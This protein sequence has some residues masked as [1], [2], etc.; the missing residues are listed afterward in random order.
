MRGRW[1]SG[2]VFHV[3]LHEVLLLYTTVFVGEGNGVAVLCNEMHL[4]CVCFKMAALIVSD[5]NLSF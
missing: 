5:I 4:L 1:V 2:N 3:W